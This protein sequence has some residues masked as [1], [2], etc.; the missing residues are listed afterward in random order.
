MPW[1]GLYCSG[2][3]HIKVAAIETSIGMDFCLFFHILFFR[4]CKPNPSTGSKIL[5]PFARMTWDSPD[6]FYDSI[7]ACWRMTVTPTAIY[8]TNAIPLMSKAFPYDKHSRNQESPVSWG[9]YLFCH[10]ISFLCILFAIPLIV[11]LVA[12][13]L[14]TK[15]KSTCTFHVDRYVRFG[16]PNYH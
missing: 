4:D 15:L 11:I 13:L 16:S 7:P 10:T 12:E 5:F 8:L 6:S 14:S 9:A 2:H 3:R 1:N